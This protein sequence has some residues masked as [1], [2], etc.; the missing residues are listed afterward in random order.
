MKTLYLVRHG[1]SSWE[2]P[3]YHD[4][5][6]PLIEKGISRT[7]KIAD[8]LAGKNVKPDLV[9]SSI[10]VRAYETAKLLAARLEYPLE[11]IEKEEAIYLNGVSALENAALSLDDKLNEVMLVGHNPDMTNFANIFL[12][13]KISYLPTTGVVAVRF[14]TS[15]WS[16][17]FICPRRILFV[18]TPRTL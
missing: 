13:Q 8:Y 16:E 10:A 14:E 2:N 12:T 3:D 5:E 7:R 15:Q 9:I 17:M 1:K 6:R 4:S 18:I 11:S